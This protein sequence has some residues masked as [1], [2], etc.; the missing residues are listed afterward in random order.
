[1]K[2]SRRKRDS[3]PGSSALEAD[4]LPLGQEHHYITC[5]FS[6]KHNFFACFVFN[7]NSFTPLVTGRKDVEHKAEKHA[8]QW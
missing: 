6:A 1:M 4:A 8:G 5:V 7:M 3:N 2:K